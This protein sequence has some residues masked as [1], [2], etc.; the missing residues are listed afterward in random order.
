MEILHKVALV[1]AV[2]LPMWNIPFIYRII[3]RRSS[4]DVSLSWALGVWICLILMA[5]SGFTSDD[6]VW[7]V[8][9]VVNLI[10]FSLVVVTVFLFRK[11]K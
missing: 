10:L 9:N 5:P 1:A 7:R 6:V 8:F 3:Q 4:Q 11:A 2:V